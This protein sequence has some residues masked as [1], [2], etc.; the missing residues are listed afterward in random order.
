[1]TSLPSNFPR[2][3][4]IR[5][6]EFGASARAMHR[7]AA[8]ENA[9]SATI[10]RKIMST[11]TT[12]KRVSLVAV[13]AL[14]FGLLSVVPSSAGTSSADLTS[15][16]SAT[17]T[18]TVGTAVS[19][20]VTQSFLASGAA[21]SMT[22]NA[23]LVSVP[24]GAALADLPTMGLTTSN[25]NATTSV[26]NTSGTVGQGGVAAA[27]AGYT[28][29][30]FTAT[31]TPT[32]AGTYVIKFIGAAGAGNTGTIQGV[33]VNWTVTVAAL[34][35]VT[36][37]NST[38]FLNT[39]ETTAATTDATVSA[40]LTLNAS[41]QAASIVVTPKNAAGTD[42]TAT[43]ALT[44]TISGPGT[45]AISN[46]AG[47][48]AQVAS[49]RAITGTAGQN[50]IG[51]FSDGTSGVATVTI[52]AGT[53]VLST[54]TVTFYGA[55]ASIVATVVNPVVAVGSTGPNVGAIT[56][57]AKDAN[58]TTVPAGNLYATSD[59]AAV[60]SNS[61]S[62]AAIG[63]TTAGVATFTLTGVALG[64]A[65]ITIGT[66][67]SST[68]TTFVN[69]AAVAVRVGSATP[70]TVSVSFDKTSYAP[71]EA[72][73]V[74]VSLK[75]ATGLAVANGTYAN[76]F[77]TGGLVSNF[78]LGG[79]AINVT[80]ITPSG[81]TGAQTFAVSM[82]VV[83]ADVFL[84]AT[85]GTG[86]PTAAQVALTSGTVNVSSPG[87]AAAVDAANAAT[88]AANYAADA[89]DA[90][91]TAAQEATAAAQAAQDSADAATAAVVA[92]GLRVDTLMASVRA[93]LTSLSNLLVRIIKKTHA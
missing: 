88:D 41:A 67:S 45:L 93:Q 2:R 37:A 81:S 8:F 17:S 70:A 3:V 25:T 91:T 72:A 66:A 52:S 74:T 76:I 79:V 22:V 68:V 71:G 92:L 53:T 19:I 27:A 65:N 26:T 73:T 80:S 1:M 30:V 43:T 62:V 61:Y 49:G 59:A 9:S 20:N 21:D 47:V 86:L 38:S 55:I 46:V 40:P 63:G 13:A 11:K 84:S 57:V 32:A 89:A 58:G 77:A 10:E 28:A 15:L 60:V 16:S 48:A 31:F 18:G 24:A 69:A 64:T 87:N 5:G 44:A 56:A 14:G 35:A 4:R 51:V 90:A 29:G 83:E 78:A 6:G 82:P 34:G 23:S 39:G 75:D 54:E 7:K 50:V 36:A 33:A 42:L 85:G 12:L